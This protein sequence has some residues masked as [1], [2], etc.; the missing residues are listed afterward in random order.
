[1]KTGDAE[2]HRGFESHLLRFSLQ[3]FTAQIAVIFLPKKIFF[4]V[5]NNFEVATY[6]EPKEKN[7]VKK[8]IEKNDKC[9]GKQ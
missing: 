3:N 2:R 4:Q 8:E 1:M 5:I 9:N 6:N 7:K